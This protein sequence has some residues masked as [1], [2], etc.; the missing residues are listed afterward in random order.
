[1]LAGL[2]AGGGGVGGGGAFPRANGGQGRGGD[3]GSGGHPGFAYGSGGGG[4]FGG[5]GA[6]S[7]DQGT[8]SADGGFGGGG[9]YSAPGGFGGGNGGVNY[10]NG[11]QVGGGGAG[12]GGAIFNMQGTLKILASTLAANFASGGTVLNDPGP[13][14]FCGPY[15]CHPANGM[16]GE[17][18]GGAVFNLNSSFTAVGST[19]AL[20]YADAG[21]GTEIFNLGYDAATHRIALTTL[22]DTIVG[23][24]LA[25]TGA[26]FGLASVLPAQTS[27]GLTNL[28]DAGGDAR[29]FDLVETKLAIG[30]SIIGS[31]LTADPKLGSL[32]D[33][34]GATQTAAPLAGSPVI[35]AAAASAHVCLATDQRGKRRPDNGEARCDLGAYEVQDLDTKITKAAIEPRKRRATFSFKALGAASGFQCAL[36]RRKKSHHHRA[37]VRFSNCTTPRTYKHLKP[38]RY[39]FEVRSLGLGGPDPTP[40]RTSFR[41]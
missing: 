6:G 34:G 16:P 21:R 8:G 32:K 12:M 23:R 4:G 14:N 20:N 11:T 17:G 13:S 2:G 1:M 18:L 24:G 31:P 41:I 40:A 22:E 29:R 19:F 15:T 35:D 25:G 37:Q 10:D 3:F 28:A 30:N 36:V 39:K 27:R 38:A 33:N 7:D 9:G 26:P 5:G